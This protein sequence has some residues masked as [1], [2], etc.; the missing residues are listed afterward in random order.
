MS[1]VPSVDDLRLVD[2]I[3]R[4]GSIGAAARD[5][6]IAQPSASA[7]LA[8]LERRLGLRLFDRDTTG[9]RVTDAGRAFADEAAHVLSHLEMLPE[10]V[11]AGAGA[12]LLRV[13]TFPSLAA[14]LFPALDRT[15]AEINH[16]T[17]LGA[18][19]S[20]HQYVDHGDVLIRLVAE[21]S[22]DV[23]VIA[24]AD[25]LPL[26]PAITTTPLGTDHLVAVAPPGT[27]LTRR[28]PFTGTVPFHSV[29]MSGPAIEQRITELGGTP[30]RCATGE[31][32]VLT[33][34]ATGATALLAGAIAA[35]YRHPDEH[36]APA[37]IRQRFTFHLVTR[38]PPP[39]VVRAIARPLAAHMGLKHL[40]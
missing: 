3:R 16:I 34:R 7:R 12:P 8:G 1:Y 11:R 4:H 10:R 9:A 23:A 25:Q 6:L 29:D 22:L 31:V 37:P 35:V 24:V 5:L 32:A 2:A 30:R 19:V 33:A 18:P 13:A 40:G 17:E 21:A 38:T 39:A 28:R 20:V 36:V 15:L 14:A 26:A 27:D